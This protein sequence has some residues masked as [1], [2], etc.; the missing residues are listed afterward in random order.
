MSSTGQATFTCNF[1]LFVDALAYYAKITG[2]DLSTNPFTDTLKQ[3]NSPGAILELLQGSDKA[4]IEYRDGNRRLIGYLNPAVKLFQAFSG[5]L[6]EGVS[7]VRHTCHLASL[8]SNAASSGSL[9]TSKCFAC[10]D[11]CPSCCTSLE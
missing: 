4:F 8:Y 5:I 1:Q 6:G 9:P 10:R 7:L 11:R 3:L 2:V